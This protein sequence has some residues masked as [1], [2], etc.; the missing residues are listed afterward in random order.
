[1][2]AWSTFAE[3]EFA[4]SRFYANVRVYPAGKPSILQVR[5]PGN[6]LLHRLSCWYDSNANYRMNEAATLEFSL[7]VTEPAVTAGDV[8]APN[9]VWYYNGA[10]ELKTK[11]VIQ[12]VEIIAEGGGRSL[13]VRCE[14]Y[15]SR[16]RDDAVVLSLTGDI[17]VTQAV[18]SILAGQVS[19]VQVKLG[20]IDAEIASTT[21]RLE[22][23]DG[24]TPME[25]LNEI[26]EQVGGYFYVDSSRALQWREFSASA[27]TG[28]VFHLDWNVAGYREKRTTARIAN[29]VY[30][31]GAIDPDGVLVEVDSGG[32]NYIEDTVSQAAYGI[33]IHR[34]NNRRIKTATAANLIAQQWVDD[35]ANPPTERTLPAVDWQSLKAGQE[36]D[37][38]D[39]PYQGV[40]TIGRKVKVRRPDWAPDASWSP[41]MEATWITGLSVDLARPWNPQV[42]FG[43]IEDDFFK[44]VAKLDEKTQ[45]LQA[46]RNAFDAL[47]D[48]LNDPTQVPNTFLDLDDT[49]SSYTGQARKTVRVNSAETALEF[50]LDVAIVSTTKSG[51]GTLADPGIGEVTAD[52]VNEGTYYW[53]DGATVNADWLMFTFFIQAT[54]IANLGNPGKWMLGWVST[55]ADEGLYW[56][57]PDGTANGEWKPV[58]HY[59]TSS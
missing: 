48:A 35:H 46:E 22:A 57:A 26:R 9:E 11:F 6:N 18:T 29:R 3:Q 19:D 28:L 59:S 23:T 16:L 7:P 47:D 5:T 24:A 33:R 4:A 53:R 30:V 21:V 32:N 55:G 45:I 38:D 37:T 17:T 58:N 42:T 41:D 10:A 49:P 8:T 13:R 14:D 34:I 56:Y 27:Q 12:E 39:D 44:E 52:T 15:L 31:Q 40:G 43:V 20:T 1:M 25:L 36:I 50:N 51:L 2:F 54:S